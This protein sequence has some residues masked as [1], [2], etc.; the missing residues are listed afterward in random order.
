[1]VET[2]FNRHSTPAGPLRRLFHR[3]AHFF[4]YTLNKRRSTTISRAAG[5][6][7]RVPP[8]VFHPRLFLTSEFFAAFIAE[9]DLKGRRVADVGTGS[10]VLALAAAKAG[11]ANV[12]AID[13]NPHATQATV[14]NARGNGLEHGVTGVCSDMLSAIAARPLFDVILSNPPCFPGEP[15]DLADRSW[16]AGPDYRDIASLFEQ[17]HERLV[18]DGRIYVLLSSEAGLP[19]LC[20]LMERARL[21]ARLVKERSIF[22]ES[23]LMYEL[24]KH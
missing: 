1:M 6:R 23:M 13:I 11:A 19:A 24:Q 4:S 18:P 15:L 10:G 16:R 2:A 14:E 17:A 7:L 22:V 21:R 12:V 20:A 9:L 8:T 3:T 5:F